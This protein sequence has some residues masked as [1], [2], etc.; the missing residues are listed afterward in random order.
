MLK[1]QTDDSKHQNKSAAPFHTSLRD[2][3]HDFIFTVPFSISFFRLFPQFF[4]Q[5][6]F[7]PFFTVF[8]FSLF[9]SFSSSL[10]FSHFSVPFPVFSPVFFQSLLF[11]SFFSSF[12]HFFPMFWYLEILLLPIPNKYYHRNTWAL[13]KC[14]S[15]S[16]L[17]LKPL[18]H[19]P[20]I[21]WHSSEALSLS[22]PLFSSA[23]NSLRFSEYISN[24][25]NIHS[26][27]LSTLLEFLKDSQITFF[28]SQSSG[29]Y[30]T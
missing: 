19:Y 5:S 8:F 12:S 29:P 14:V 6:Y 20:F 15:A 2:S 28:G 25:H 26:T 4:F 11:P 7:Q 17:R 18:L 21:C 24:W 16:K 23:L 27:H 13:V 1:C 10:I 9:S 30:R 3:Y 22:T